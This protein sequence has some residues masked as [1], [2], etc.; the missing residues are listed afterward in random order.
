MQRILGKGI[1][2]YAIKG[3]L[4][5]KHSFCLFCQ[6]NFIHVGFI[7]F[8][9]NIERGMIV[10]KCIKCKSENVTIQMVQ[11]SKKTKKHGNGIGGHVNN[12]ARGFTAVC[13]LGMSNIVWKKSKGNEKTTIQNKKMC[14]CQK[15]GTSWEIS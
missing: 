7:L 11:T 8:L 9:H 14:V 10:M 4:K 13:T 5:N 6:W 1:F 3:P 2:E 12:A 15:C